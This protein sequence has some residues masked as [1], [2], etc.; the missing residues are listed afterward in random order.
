[1]WCLISSAPVRVLPEPIQSPRRITDTC[2]Y[3]SGIYPDG[4]V[5]YTVTGEYRILS[6]TH[7]LIFRRHPS[8][9]IPSLNRIRIPGRYHPLL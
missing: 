6:M 8:D 7:R 4:E 1:M 9:P 5:G 2:V 3:L